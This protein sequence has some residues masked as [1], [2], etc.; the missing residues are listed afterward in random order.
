[1]ACCGKLKSVSNIV[2]GNINLLAEKLFRLDTLRHERGEQRQR[3][4]MDCEY[5]TWLTKSFYLSWL[6]KNLKV[7]TTHIE[8][9]TTLPD[10]PKEENA[11]GK[12]LFCMKCKCWI[13]AKT[14]A[15]DA[16]CPFNKW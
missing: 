11:S 6:A 14:R 13:P 15:L 3:I 5:Q 7:I 8:D 9:L 10:L 12:K 16:K 2:S 1:M 4:C